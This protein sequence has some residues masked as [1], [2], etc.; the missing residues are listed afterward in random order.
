MHAIWEFMLIT[1]Q[2]LLL[3][4]LYVEYT[5]VERR[6]GTAVVHSCQNH[7]DKQWLTSLAVGSFHT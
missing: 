6:Q 3:L 1:N 2:Y 4:F 7:A 5:G